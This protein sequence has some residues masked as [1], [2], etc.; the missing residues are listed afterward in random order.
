MMFLEEFEQFSEV[1]HMFVADS[2][3]N[4]TLNN[5]EMYMLPVPAQ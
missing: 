4:E 5:D 2:F 3:E 1:L